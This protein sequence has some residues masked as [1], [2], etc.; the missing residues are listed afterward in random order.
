VIK[1]NSCIHVSCRDESQQNDDEFEKEKMDQKII[2]RETASV[3]NLHVDELSLSLSPILF[4]N[5]RTCSAP[6]KGITLKP[7]PQDQQIAFL[8][9]KILTNLETV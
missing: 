6:N 2:R 5:Y 7:C 1:Y 9:T 4:Y 3:S 8:I